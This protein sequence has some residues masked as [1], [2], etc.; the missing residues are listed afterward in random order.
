MPLRHLLGWATGPR[1]QK[2]KIKDLE[3]EIIRRKRYGEEHDTL[4]QELRML[5]NRA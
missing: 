1:V 3:K 4:L 5:K 2:E